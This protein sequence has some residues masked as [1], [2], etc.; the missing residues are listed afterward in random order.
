MYCTK[1]GNKITDNSNFCVKCGNKI[2]NE[3]FNYNYISENFKYIRGTNH[4]IGTIER[5]LEILKDCANL[6]NTTKN[7]KVFFERYLLAI[8]IL[9][10]LILIEQQ[11]KK[12]F[13]GKQPTQLK[14]QLIEK[15]INTVNDFIDRYYMDT[16]HKISQF[17]TIKSK[18]NKSVLFCNGLNEYKKYLNKY[19]FE[20]YTKL[21]AELTYKYINIDK[22]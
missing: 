18:K 19:S 15:E 21:S 3:G 11:Y 5:C 16:L 4:Y 6:I 20:K 10:E 13:I 14:R 22:T 1:C 8:S 2:S 17:K 9:N 7:P 12:V